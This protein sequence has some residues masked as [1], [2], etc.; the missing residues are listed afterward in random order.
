MFSGFIESGSQNSSNNYFSFGSGVNNQT[1]GNSF[2][3]N[4]VLT[5]V[6]LPTQFSVNNGRFITGPNDIYFRIPGVGSH[7][8][9]ALRWSLE[10]SKADTGTLVYSAT[11][12]IWSGPDNGGFNRPV[13][14]QSSLITTFNYNDPGAATTRFQS[15]AN[16]ADDVTVNGGDYIALVLIIHDV[17]VQ[18]N[19]TYVEASV[20]FG[21]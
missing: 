12:G 1:A 13:L 21:L 3:Y 19:I 2:K 20:Q 8:I 7:K 11:I 17:N 18:L 10:Y 6:S 5:P 15:G 9:R 4:T 16:L 14:T